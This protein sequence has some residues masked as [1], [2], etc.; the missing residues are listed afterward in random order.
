MNPA[1]LIGVAAAILTTS[2]FVPQAV[3]V[4]RTRETGAISLAMYSLFTAGVSLWFAYGLLTQQWTIVAANGIT[5]VFAAVILAMK[6]GEGAR[7][8]KANRGR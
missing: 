2:A 7:A 6:L 3:K 5:L 8:A 4:V 1:E